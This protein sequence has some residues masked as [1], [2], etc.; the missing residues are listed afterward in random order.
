MKSTL[1]Q[2]LKGIVLLLQAAIA[3]CATFIAIVITLALV[4]FAAIGIRGL[5]GLYFE[6]H[7]ADDF[8][9]WVFY[10]G[11][12]CLFVLAAILIASVVKGIPKVA[13]KL[14][15]LGNQYDALRE[16]EKQVENAR[17]KLRERGGYR[18]K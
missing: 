5:F 1:K 15:D 10:T 8:P 9:S 12:V 3:E 4:G 18:D 14:V 17:G 13:R 2:S 16:K 7:P 6:G 11:Y